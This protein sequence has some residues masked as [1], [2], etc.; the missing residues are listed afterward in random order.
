M[1]DVIVTSLLNT[2]VITSVFAFLQRGSIAC[3]AEGCISYD[4]FC[5][6]VWQ[7]AHAGIMPKRHQLRSCGLHWRIVPM[8][9]VSWRLTSARN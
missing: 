7:S 5:L 6:T 4:R 1:Y 8:T 2:D 3:F 9:L